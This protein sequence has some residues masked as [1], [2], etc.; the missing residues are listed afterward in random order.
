MVEA[1]S[2][3]RRGAVFRN[4]GHE[5][6]KVL[7][8]FKLIYGIT[9]F[10]MYTGFYSLI[11]KFAMDATTIKREHFNRWYSTMAYYLAM[12]LTDVWLITACTVIF[13]TTL[14]IMTDQPI[15]EEFRYFMFLGLQLLMSFVAQGFGMMVGSLFRLMVR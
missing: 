2:A 12:T 8:T 6:S 14:Y 15:D 5:A 9:I 13:V 7:S 10:L 4:S 3:H 1:D 11:T